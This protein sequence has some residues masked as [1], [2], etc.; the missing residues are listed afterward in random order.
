MV[1]GERARA[2]RVASTIFWLVLLGLGGLTALFMLAAPLLMRPFGDPGGDVDLA[3]GLS[4]VLFPIVVL[5]GLSGIIVAI[6]NSYEQFAVPALA[7]VLW[8]VAIIAGLAIGVPAADG[9]D[10]ELYVYAGSVL[11]ATLLQFLLP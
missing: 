10:A 11:I 8:N 1:K 2:W 9:D 4:R 5:L 6:L 7:P 3:V